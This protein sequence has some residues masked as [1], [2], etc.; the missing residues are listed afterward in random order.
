MYSTEPFTLLPKQFSKSQTHI[1]KRAIK[2]KTL[3]SSLRKPQFAA[4]YINIK[5]KYAAVTAAR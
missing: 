5:E 3:N 1:Y 2:T 4:V